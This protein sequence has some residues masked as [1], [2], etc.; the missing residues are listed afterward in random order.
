MTKLLNDKAANL[1]TF[2]I[3]VDRIEG[4]FAVC[5]FPDETM[6]DIHLAAFEELDTEVREREQYRV[7]LR[8]EGKVEVLSKVF[9]LPNTPQKKLSAKLVRFI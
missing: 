2:I 5:E 4:D 9:L 8:E 7:C 6:H 1:S 3:F